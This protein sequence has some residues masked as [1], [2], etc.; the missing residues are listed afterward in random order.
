MPSKLGIIA[1]RGELPA[2][3]IEACRETGRDFFVIAIEGQAEP[4]SVA[5]TPHVWLRLG[6]ADT[7]FA[8]LHEEGAEEVVLAGAIKRPSL[9]ALRPDARGARFLAR[10]ARAALGDDTLLSAV[11]REFE[12]AGFRVVGPDD[13]LGSMVAEPR[14]YGKTAPDAQAQSDIETAMHVARVLGRLDI[15]QAV[16]VQQGLVLGVE[17]IEGTDALIA[18]CGELRREGPGGVLVKLKKPGQERRVDLPTIGAHTVAAAAAA[19]LRGIAVEAGGALI[20]DPEAVAAKADAAGL[21]VL[22]LEVAE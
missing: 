21:F 18:R 14:L 13:I 12:A 10:L 16:V 9:G 1:G 19:G 17:A 22:G 20:L 6:A 4:E 3:I 15:G 8:R 7:A 2:R 11:V 5:G